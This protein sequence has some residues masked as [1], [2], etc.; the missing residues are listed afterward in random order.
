MVA[1]AGPP[2]LPASYYNPLP[3]AVKLRRR[4]P[5]GSQGSSVLWPSARFPK[6]SRLR[7]IHFRPCRKRDIQLNKPHIHKPMAPA[8][9]SI[10]YSSRANIP[11]SS[12][13][14]N[15]TNHQALP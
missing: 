13:S 8:N 7:A 11:T 9:L 2:V 15:I 5:D 1:A 12:A 4:L 6:S 3:A 10:T 14:T